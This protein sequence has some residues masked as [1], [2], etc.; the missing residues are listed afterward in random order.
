MAFCS[1]REVQ[2]ITLILKNQEL[3]QQIDK[4]AAA[5]PL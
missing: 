2:A 3:T 4:I 5:C 1:V